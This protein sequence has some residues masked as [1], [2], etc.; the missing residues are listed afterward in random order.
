M[1]IGYYPGW[2]TGF[3]RDELNEL[4]NDGQRKK[5]AAKIDFDLHMLETTWPR[6]QFVSIKSLKGHEPLYELIREYQGIAY[7]VF[8]CAKGQ[9]IWL[10]H[11]IEKKKQ[12]T[13]AG[14]LNLAFDRMQDVLNGKVRRP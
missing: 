12:K 11:V 10:L 9:E 3:V 13:P 7:R 5:A 6:P 8:F 1:T 14:D 4:R 2:L